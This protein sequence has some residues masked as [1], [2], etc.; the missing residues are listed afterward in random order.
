M[1]TDIWRQCN[2]KPTSKINVKIVEVMKRIKTE[3]E[4]FIRKEMIQ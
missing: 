3:G 4:E 2:C 1:A